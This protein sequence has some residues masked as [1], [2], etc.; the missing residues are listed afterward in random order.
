M[1]HRQLSE[2]EER[3]EEELESLEPRRVPKKESKQA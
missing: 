1:K 3:F 2:E